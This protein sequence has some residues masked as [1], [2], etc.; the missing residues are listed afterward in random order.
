MAS[1]LPN[2]SS[3]ILILFYIGLVVWWFMIF[4]RGITETTEN[5]LYSFVY[6]LIPLIWGLIGLRNSMLWGGLKSLMG[7]SIAFL[8]L[9][10]LA[11]AIG[12]LVWAYY[13]LIM[14]VPVPYPSPADFI[15]ILSFPLW[16]IG[17][18]LLSR[19]T[20][21]VFSLR[22]VRGKIILFVIPILAIALSYY[23]LFTVARG[24]VIDTEGGL[25]KFFLD[26]AFPVWDVII[27]TLALLV[28]GLSFNYLG[29]RFKWPIIILLLGFGVNYITD[30]SFSYTTT[31]GTFFV[32]SWVDLLFATA[33]FLIALGVA[34]LSPQ[35]IIASEK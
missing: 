19:V 27:L 25:L 6:G 12:N 7:K 22:R 31:L 33:M 29:G 3:K 4:A 16:A 32:G 5:Y 20:G 30:F 14:R 26:I 17:I 13:N 21:M 18:S 2:W 1:L 8:S 28:F 10:L 11:W 15:F 24:G 23:L 35:S 34:L 9:G